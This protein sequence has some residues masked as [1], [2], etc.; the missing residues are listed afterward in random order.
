MQKSDLFAALVPVIC[1]LCI[2]LKVSFD[3]FTI[4]C[5]TSELL[6]EIAIIDR[7]LDLSRKTSNPLVLGMHV[8]N[9]KQTVIT[10]L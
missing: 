2:F 9:E 1:H 6:V 4:N 3:F 7:R 5:T 10:R 8:A